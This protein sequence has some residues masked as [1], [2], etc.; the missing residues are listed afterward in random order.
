[1]NLT[2]L[3]SSYFSDF[4]F[5]LL[6]YIINLKCPWERQN[7][8]NPSN[9]NPTIGTLSSWDAQGYGPLFSYRGKNTWIESIQLQEP[10][11]SLCLV[12]LGHALR[13]FVLPSQTVLLVPPHWTMQAG[14]ASGQHDSRSKKAYQSLERRKVNL[15]SSPCRPK[16]QDGGILKSGF[17]VLFNCPHACFGRCLE[18]TWL[19][20]DRWYSFLVAFVRWHIRSS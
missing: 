19:T 15:K 6:L 12:Q 17:V 16:T 11:G 20:I 5:L 3:L 8:T 18:T 4:F 1:M 2:L 7:R 13:I 9:T 10:E 14:P